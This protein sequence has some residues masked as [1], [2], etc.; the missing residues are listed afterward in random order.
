MKRTGILLLTL[1]VSLSLVAC[2]KKPADSADS[3][4]TMKPEAM[5]PVPPTK[6]TPPPKV[7]VD[8]KGADANWTVTITKANELLRVL[9][10][11]KTLADVKKHKDKLVALQIDM[12]KLNLASAKKA[13]KLDKKSLR[14][15]FEKAAAEQVKQVKLG[16]DIQAEMARVGKIKGVKKIQAQVLKQIGAQVTP[17]AKE[18]Q[19]LDAKLKAKVALPAKSLP[20]K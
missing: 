19:A 15:Y 4:G 2:K 14:V 1:V 20:S 16:Q 10:G 7:V 13:E 17:I 3:K 8:L 18:L 12:M 9:K 11:V 5:Q 6:P